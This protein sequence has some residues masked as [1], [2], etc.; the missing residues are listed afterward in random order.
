MISAK[1]KEKR[2]TIGVFIKFYLTVLCCP[3]LTQPRQ[4]RVIS[5][6]FLIKKY[7]SWWAKESLGGPIKSC[8]P[9]E[10]KFVKYIN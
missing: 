5:S 4:G 10:S 1:E 7:C 8:H 3:N 9:S 2:I 6:A